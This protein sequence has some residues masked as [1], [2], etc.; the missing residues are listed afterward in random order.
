VS[1]V[2]AVVLDATLYGSSVMTTED[3]VEADSARP[4][5]LPAQQSTGRCP[6]L[7]R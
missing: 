4:Y 1:P 2:F 5:W 7:V 3:T 6:T